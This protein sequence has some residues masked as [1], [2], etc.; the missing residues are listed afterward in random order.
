MIL[1]QTITICASSACIQILCR[2]IVIL[3]CSGRF[4]RSCDG[5]R[6]VEGSAGCQ[7]VSQ[8]S[9]PTGLRSTCPSYAPGLRINGYSFIYYY[10]VLRQRWFGQMI[11]KSSYEQVLFENSRRVYRVSY[12][13]GSCLNTWD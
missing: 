12:A 4:W 2:M 13:I 1:A 6:S 5:I 10:I 11:A 8:G 3:T 7:P 9:V